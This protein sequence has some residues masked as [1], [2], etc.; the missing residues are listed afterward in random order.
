MAFWNNDQPVRPLPNPATR[1]PASASVMLMDA[2]R[3]L[4]SKAACNAVY[5]ALA[6][7]KDLTA[8]DLEELSNRIGRLAW[9]RG[10]K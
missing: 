10:R 2:V 3:S 9:E 5:T 8:D 1:S 4:P 6:D 7:K